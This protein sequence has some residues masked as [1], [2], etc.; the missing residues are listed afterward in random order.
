MRDNPKT[1]DK[2]KSQFK[3]WAKPIRGKTNPEIMTNDVWV[4]LV[5]SN[6][7]PHAAHECAGKGKKQSPGW[8]FSRFGQSETKLADGTI[9]YIAGEHE[10]H[11]DE[12][13]HIY[14][15]VII[16][17]AD[18]S[19]VIYGYPEDI[20]PPTD[21]HSATLVG[22][23]IYII[24]STLSRKDCYDSTSVYILNLESY[25]IRCFQ[26]KGSSPPELFEHKAK[27]SDDGAF[28]ICTE[29]KVR[30]EKSGE[31]VENITTWQL[32]LS[33]GE[34]TKLSEKLW[35]RW[36]LRREDEEYNQLYEISN[37]AYAEEM[38]DKSSY[39]LKEYDKY[40][41][42]FLGQKNSPD[43][44]AYRKRY[45]PDVAH[46]TVAKNEDDYR[47]FRIKVNDIIVR[48]Y[49]DSDD[50]TVTVEGVLPYD[51]VSELKEYGLNI[52]SKIEGVPYKIIEI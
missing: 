17:H 43:L 32:N 23:E 37:L 27:L 49:E 36:I 7:W 44:S 8:C 13:Y 25:E 12:D 41:K 20:F 4:W 10:D 33:T 46:E 30:D 26:T 35:T 42:L 22:N 21:G 29:G 18:D 51:I 5:Q 47:V 34:W 9:I 6:L 14:N 31:T 24:G 52:F 2:I 15:D 28:I 45:T 11:Y 1:N 50:I 39:Y 3:T 19:I 16:R 48:Y 40:K 38:K